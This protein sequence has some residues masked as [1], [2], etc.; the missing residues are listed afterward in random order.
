MERVQDMELV[1]KLLMKK[2]IKDI[3]G[4]NV[5]ISDTP[6]GKQVYPIN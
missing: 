6:Y 1:I 3:F 2:K 5:L 4:M